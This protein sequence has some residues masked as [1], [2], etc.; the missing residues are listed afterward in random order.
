[1]ARTIKAEILLVRAGFILLAFFVIALLWA[2][3]EAFLP[4]G[5]LGGAIRGTV[6]FA[7]FYLAWNFSMQL[8]ERGGALHCAPREKE[9]ADQQDQA[10]WAKLFATADGPENR[11]QAINIRLSAKRRQRELE[12]ERAIENIGVRKVLAML[13]RFIAQF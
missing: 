4:E 7:L 8:G 13:D 11:R 10:L 5:I 3:S 6:S 2:V 1:M 12:E 9:Q